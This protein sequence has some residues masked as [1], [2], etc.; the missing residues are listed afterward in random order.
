M[1]VRFPSYLMAAFASS[2]LAVAASSSCAAISPQLPL[3]A[4]A[5]P[6]SPHRRASYSLH[7]SPARRHRLASQPAPLMQPTAESRVSTVVD[8]D[9]G[10]RSY[11]IYIGAGL[12]DEQDLLQRQ[13]NYNFFSTVKCMILISVCAGMFM[14][15]DGRAHHQL[16]LYRQFTSETFG[17]SLLKYFLTVTMQVHEPI[18]NLWTFCCS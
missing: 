16:W 11:L 4:P 5:P 6:P 9:L 15:R 14:V 7:A 3:G 18:G 10:N 1:A 8:V 12:Q 13:S 17:S 2:L